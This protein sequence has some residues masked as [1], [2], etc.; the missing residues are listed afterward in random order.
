MEVG[1]SPSDLIG[2]GKVY[3][4]MYIKL[5]AAISILRNYLAH[6]D[7]ADAVGDDQRRPGRAEGSALADL[8]SEVIG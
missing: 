3:A 8:R 2:V 6:D 4:G 1:T 5:A 7:Q